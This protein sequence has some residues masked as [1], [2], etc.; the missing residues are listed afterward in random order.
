MT[1][2]ASE[3]SRMNGYMTRVSVTVSA[4]L[5]GSNPGASVATSHGRREDAE[6]GDQAQDDRGQGR[7]LVG[8]APGGALVPDGGGLAEHGDE[9]RRQRPFGEQVAQ[10]VGD[11][12]GDGERV[13]HA[14]AAEQGG[15][16]LLARQP[17][18]AAAQHREPDD[19]RGAGVQPLG[20]LLS[21]GRG[22]RCFTWWH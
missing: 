4:A 18:H 16:D 17:E 10:Q 11:A 5:A 6:H 20:A 19:P 15:E 13:H 1:R 2:A 22:R 9:G 21:A 7:D 3:T 8:Q 14:P 12:E